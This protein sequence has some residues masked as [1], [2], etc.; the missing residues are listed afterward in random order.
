MFLLKSFKGLLLTVHIFLNSLVRQKYR[1]PG[2]LVQRL[3]TFNTVETHRGFK[4]QSSNTC[5]PNNVRE[6]IKQV[7][8]QRH[9]N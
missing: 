1:S 4:N 6:E 8:G 7:Q 2:Y 3:E 9:D 5:Q